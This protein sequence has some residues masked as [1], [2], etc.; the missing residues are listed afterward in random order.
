MPD[1]KPIIVYD[2]AIQ[3]LIV[4]GLRYLVTI[5]GGVSAVLGLLGTRDLVGLIVYFR[6]TDGLALI[7]AFVAIGT[8]AYGAWKAY[9][10]KTKLVTVAEA[11][12]DN[13]AVVK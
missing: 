11:A 12:P 13:V 7:G 1:D 2:R 8:T 4:T 10:N 5:T 6:S 3:D 9:H